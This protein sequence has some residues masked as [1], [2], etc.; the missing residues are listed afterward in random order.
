MKR[1]CAACGAPSVVRK[2][3]FTIGRCYGDQGI[4]GEFYICMGCWTDGP[5]TEKWNETITQRI[6]ERERAKLV[7]RLP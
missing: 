3:T 1:C 5:N 2:S 4:S 6:I 7:V